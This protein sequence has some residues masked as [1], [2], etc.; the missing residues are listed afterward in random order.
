MAGAA[1]LIPSV[2]ESYAECEAIARQHAGNFYPAFRILP[3]DQ[4]LAICALYA[5]MRIADDLSDEPGPIP[6]KRQQ[7]AQWRQGL[8]QCV[9]GTFSHRIHPALA[10]AVLRYRIPLEYLEALIDGVEMDLESAEYRMF[11]DLKIYCYRVASVVGLCCIHIWGFSKPEAKAYAETAGLA[12]QLTNILRDLGEDAGR[13]RVYLPREELERFGYDA[14]RLQRGVIDEAFRALMRF[15]IGRARDLYEQA[16]PLLPLLDPPGR[17]VFFM[18]ASTYRQLL[19]AIE[20]QD[21]DVFSQR[22]RVSRWRKAWF[23]LRALPYRLGW[24]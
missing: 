22:A 4:R 9:A 12:F 15:Q 18:M 14:D 8:R 7:L 5:F 23:A 10:D 19:S 1:L 13:G 16:W 21:F 24:K 2:A 17:A 6:T 3:H 20:R 11:D